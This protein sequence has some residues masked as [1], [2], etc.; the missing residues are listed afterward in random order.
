MRA[1]FWRV[2][3]VFAG[4]SL[5]SSAAVQG[6]APTAPAQTPANGEP[7][8]PNGPGD[9]KAIVPSAVEASQLD[10]FLL[11]DSKGN[12]VPVLGMTFDEFEQLLKIKKG[13]TPAPPPGY[14]LD[15]LS[16]AGKAEKGVADL[17]VTVTVRIRDEGWVRVP[18]GMKTAVFRQ[19]PRYEGSGEHEILYDDAT[20]GYVA[21]FRGAGAKPH[22][23]TLQCSSTLESAGEETRLNFPLPRATESSLRLSVPGPQPEP[24]LVRGE[25]IATVQSKGMDRWEI[26]VLGPA[27]DLQLNWRKARETTTVGRALFDGNG[28]I[29]VKVESES[30]ISSDAK[31]RVRSLSGPLEVFQVRLPPGMELVPTSP[32]GYSI[33]AA[34]PPP[35]SSA[36]RSAP[37]SQVVEIRLDQPTMSAAEVRLLT[38]SLPA[39]PGQAPTLTPARFEIVNAVRQRGTIDFTVEGEWQ[40]GWNEDASVRRLDIAADAA[41][42]K[43][44]ARYEYFRQPCGLV[45]RVSPRPSRISVEP[46]HAVYV[47]PRQI[48]VETTLKY[49]LRGS[50]A[51]GL[52]FHLGDTQFDRL[53][54]EDLLDAP[55]AATTDGLLHVPF[56]QGVTLP[57]ELDL[58]LETHKTLP[59]N[60]E[61]ISVLLPRSQADSVAPASVIVLAADNVELSPQTS[62]FEGLSPDTAPVPSK[63]AARQQPPLVY[64][65]LG[66]VEQARFVANAKVKLRSTV[67]AAQA[68]VRVDKQQLLVEQHLEYRIS[69]EPQR[70]FELVAPRGVATTG[71]LQVW[72][73]DEPLSVTSLPDPPA[74][75]PAQQR[76]Q[77]STPSDQ[78]G[79]VQITIRYSHSLPRWDGQK[80]LPITVPLVLP[81]DDANHQFAG[82]QVAFVLGEGMEIAPDLTGVDEFSRPTAV[83]GDGATFTW[84]KAS[85]TTR[86]ILQPVQ[87]ARFS[88][89]V[90][91]KA[92]VQTWLAPQI[93]EERV[94]F[95]LT[96]SAES[97]R[98]RLPAG[99]LPESIQAAVNAQPAATTPREPS[100]LRIDLPANGRGRE[101]VVEIWYSLP[102]PPRKAGLQAGEL[103]SAA[104]ED[105]TPPRRMYWQLAIP[106]DDHLLV[107]PAELSAEMAPRDGTSFRA[108]APLLEQRQLE[109]WMGSTRQDPLPADVNQYLFGTLGRVPQLDLVVASRRML[110][111]AGSGIALALGLLLIHVPQL[112]SATALMVGAVVLIGLS[113]AFPEAS[114][115]A[116]RAALLGLSVTAAVVVWRWLAWGR[117]AWSSSSP[118]T[119][120]TPPESPS[121]S[122]SL[123]SRN[124]RSGPITTATAPAAVTAGDLRP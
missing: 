28:E 20:G 4:L 123:P 11:R 60:A 14:T 92:W 41:A 25:G 62:Q 16:I 35:G 83:G 55:Q 102:P 57:S 58:K 3:V 115:L 71:G 45:L 38:T 18:L 61:Q 27:G 56:R 37:Q 107:P 101:C 94:A 86:W 1:G 44:A 77:F 124:E 85:P 79:L 49:R 36:G 88:S 70:S 109:D 68:T 54:P 97:I 23:L 2:A 15:A 114:V 9:P 80:P 90:C 13:L 100:L 108:P 43:L 52:T 26:T 17:Q 98:V 29:V 81:A 46:A 110:L 64:R 5:W 34:S 82:Q 40:L 63:M 116:G 96:T 31:L 65:D 112:R 47:E 21:W 78:I 75:R 19:P 106:A 53:S 91:H 99:V 12:L 121:P 95:R 113:L 66:G 33:I 76:L 69:H 39:A 93:R 51:A 118:S 87:S 104:L 22:V 73:G 122:T 120:L 10:T 103:R 8:K 72:L 7:A 32:V 119:I 30:R 105:A 84:S 67:A 59:E 42:A 111:I 74:G 48:R 6:Q 89:V 24:S 117:P 50:R